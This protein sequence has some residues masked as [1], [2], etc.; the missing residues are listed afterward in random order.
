MGLGLGVDRSDVRLRAGSA[1]EV[2]LE[3]KE[4]KFRK[5]GDGNRCLIDLKVKRF[6]NIKKFKRYSS[7]L[8]L[9][10]Y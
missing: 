4:H 3:R 8:D 5:D 2:I 6:R 9:E 10:I 1:T 7:M